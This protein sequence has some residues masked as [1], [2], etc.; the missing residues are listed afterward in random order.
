M[1]QSGETYNYQSIFEV[2]VDHQIQNNPYQQFSSIRKL[3]PSGIKSQFDQDR[4]VLQSQIINTCILTPQSKIANNLLM[5]TLL[6]YLLLRSMLP[7]W[8]H[9]GS[10][11]QCTHVHCL[12]MFMGWSGGM[13]LAQYGQQFHPPATHMVSQARRNF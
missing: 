1:N 3:P 12:T 4:F 8:K 5:L 6:I 10:Y 9:L 2:Q 13:E 11:C 7:D